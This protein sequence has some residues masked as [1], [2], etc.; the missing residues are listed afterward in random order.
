MQIKPIRTEEDNRAALARIEQLW[1]SEPNTREG[2]E[3]EVLI[4]LT[5]AFEKAH[6]PIETADPIEAIRF[7]MEQQGLED[8]DL[9]AY[10]GHRDRV[11]EVMNRQ[12]RLSIS[13]IRKLNAGL[14]ISL[15]CLVKEYPLV[16]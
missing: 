3:L 8:R 11:T 4:T 15:D 10:M 16:K 2:D 14:G 9:V 13:M 7:R 12:R 5:E 1:R 6:H